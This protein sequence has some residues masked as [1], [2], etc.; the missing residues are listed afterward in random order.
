MADTGNKHHL[1]GRFAHIKRGTHGSSNEI[2]MSVL[3]A[4]KNTL[5]AEQGEAPRQQLGTINLFT[6]NG[7]GSSNIAVPSTSLNAINAEPSDG[8]VPAQ[9]QAIPEEPAASSP[10]EERA[11]RKAEKELA[12]EQ[13][14]KVRE[15]KAAREEKAAR[16]AE[17][18]AEKA[19]QKAARKAEK[20]L[21]KKAEKAEREQGQHAQ[22]AAKEPKAAVTMPEKTMEERIAA[23]KR[24]RKIRRIAIIAALVIAVCAALGAGGYYLYTT[25]QEEQARVEVLDQ[26]LTQIELADQD[27]TRLNDALADP[28][29]EGS[30]ETLESLK[31]SLPQTQITLQRAHGLTQRGS[32]GLTSAVDQEAALQALKAIEARQQMIESG[33]VLIDATLTAL[34]SADAADETW[35]LLLAADAQAR[36]NATLLLDPTE[37]NLDQA[38]TGVKDVREQFSAAKAAMVAADEL[39]YVNLNVYETYIDKRV[40]ALDCAQQ[41][42]EALQQEDLDVA[43]EKQAAYSTADSEAAQWATKLPTKPSSLVEEAY[44]ADVAEAVESYT[45]ARTA[46]GGADDMLRD[47]YS[48]TKK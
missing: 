25:H 33:L 44:Q 6:L 38:L 27:L 17:K 8:T 24:R 35:D 26:A 28:R 29:A 32:E 34:S 16:K 2:S 1:W 9:V 11:A 23:R 43:R 36:T 18:R 31:E 37:E 12:R 45:Q 40:A 7:K 21:V 13:R 5:D 14:Q 15:A 20:E 30:K 48:N 41:A 22:H 39:E 4:A 10:E 19:Q 42:I 47:Y 3:D 46:A